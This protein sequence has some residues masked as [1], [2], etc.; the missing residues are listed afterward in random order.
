MV[1]DRDQI[2]QLLRSKGPLVP[3]EIK[4]VM[5]LDTFI[6][7]AI[8]SEL[9]SK[10]IVKITHLKKGGSPFYYLP[11]QEK[12]LEKFLEYLNPKDQKTVHLLK[13]YRVMQDDGQELFIRVSL[14]QIKDFAIPFIVQTK[15]GPLNFWRYYLISEPEALTILKERFAPKQKPNPTPKSQPELVVE[16]KQVSTTVSDTSLKSVERNPVD[17]KKSTQIQSQKEP[18][19]ESQKELVVEANLEETPFYKQIIKFF[20][21][22]NIILLSEE[23]ISK[24]KEYDFVVHVQSGIG[25]LKLFCR[26]RN[27][28]K[29]NE[30]DVA[31]ALLK[32]RMKDLSCLFLTPGEFTKKSLVLFEKEYKGLIIKKLV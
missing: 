13:E 32:A 30:G 17:Q 16:K 19:Y 22:N 15:E 12:Q 9:S 27:K 2:V 28:K 20:K 29:L 31:P 11:S 14:R 25:N 3:N 4:K 10:G 23:C 8:L 24:N 5:G 6:L 1:I 21:E 26:A 18:T 7:G